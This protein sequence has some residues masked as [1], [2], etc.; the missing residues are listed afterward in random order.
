MKTIYLS[1]M[2]RCLPGSALSADKLEGSWLKRAYEC[3]TAKEVMLCS[4]GRAVPDLR[5]PLG[6]G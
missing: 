4:V 6:A 1:D 3:D 2:S 5:L